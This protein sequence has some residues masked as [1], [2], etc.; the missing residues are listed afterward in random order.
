MLSRD[1]GR[2]LSGK[3]VVLFPAR[4]LPEKGVSQFYEAAK[5]IN[6]R[7]DQYVFLHMGHIVSEV[8]GGIG[9]DSLER[10]AEECGVLF[11]GFRKDP[12]QVMAGADIVALPSARE[13]MPRSLLEALAMGKCVV[14]TDVP[15]CRLAVKDGWNGY[16]CEYANAQSLAE[17]IVRVTDELIETCRSRSRLHCQQLFDATTVVDTTLGK[18]FSNAK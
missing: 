16:L 1:V 2:T 17:A 4:A 14:T 12:E 9:K 8:Q 11:L 6:A 7:T 13:G 18:Y 10:Y 15:G 5:R 3:R